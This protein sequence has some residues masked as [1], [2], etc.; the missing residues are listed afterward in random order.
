MNCLREEE[1]L[2]KDSW[3]LPRQAEG[4]LLI[5]GKKKVKKG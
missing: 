4:V 2:M 1:R 5:L 3:H